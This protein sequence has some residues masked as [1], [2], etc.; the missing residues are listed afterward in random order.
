MALSVNGSGTSFDL[1]D[2]RACIPFR[3][4]KRPS[5]MLLCDE[6]DDDSPGDDEAA[7]LLFEHT[8]GVTLKYLLL[9]L[10]APENPTSN[11]QMVL[12]V[13][14]DAKD[15]AKKLIEDVDAVVDAKLR[16]KYDTVHALQH[17]FHD[18]STQ[19]ED[20]KTK[21]KNVQS[22]FFLSICHFAKEKM[23]GIRGYLKTLNKVQELK[24]YDNLFLQLWQKEIWAVKSDNFLTI[25]DCLTRLT[26]EDRRSESNSSLP[27]EKNDIETPRYN[28]FEM[29]LTQKDMMRCLFKKDSIK[30]NAI[31]AAMTKFVTEDGQGKTKGEITEEFA[32]VYEQVF[33]SIAKQEARA[34]AEL[35]N[36]ETRKENFYLKF[37]PALE[38]FA[39]ENFKANRNSNI[40]NKKFQQQVQEK[41]NDYSDLVEFVED[42]MMTLEK[43]AEEQIQEIHNEQMKQEMLNFLAVTFPEHAEGGSE[44][45]EHAETSPVRLTAR[46]ARLQ[47]FR[48]N[49]HESQYQSFVQHMENLDDA[50][51]KMRD[52]ITRVKDAGR[53]WAIIERLSA[54]PAQDATATDQGKEVV[55]EAS[56]HP[57]APKSSTDENDYDSGA[58]FD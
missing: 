28:T 33:P 9:R 31:M 38:K 42:F 55:A 6:S 13:I 54:P 57:P 19:T 39:A 7:M 34:I 41:M 18:A 37:A 52:F 46:A 17:D 27:T 48:Q 15:K 16:T 25:L 40:F 3:A 11:L 26:D 8:L 5:S 35:M 58:D 56:Q 24:L 2:P 20:M 51:Q 14:R 44:S 1:N 49:R 12:E 47:R 10:S 43:G 50:V 30:Y 4:R 23:D 32:R 22:F 36:P 45:G 29:S 21:I 53:E